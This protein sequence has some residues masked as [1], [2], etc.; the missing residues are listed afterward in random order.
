MRYIRWRVPDEIEELYDLG[1]DP[2]Q[3]RILAVDSQHRRTLE[4]FRTRME[5]EIVEHLPP[6][7]IETKS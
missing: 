5:A 3:L 2:Q 1:R 4:D 6:A 7:R